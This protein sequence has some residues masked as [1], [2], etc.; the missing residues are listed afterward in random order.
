MCLHTTIAFA[1]PPDMTPT[2]VTAGRSHFALWPVD[3]A[4]L[5]QRLLPSETYFATS[6][7][8]C[9]C[10]TMI[11][12]ANH[13]AA[14]GLVPSEA[15]AREAAKLRAKGWGAHKI[16]R[17]LASKAEAQD[18][19]HRL[20]ATDIAAARESDEIREWLSLLHELTT[21]GRSVALMLHNGDV[22]D[23]TAFAE[24]TV[25]VPVVTADWLVSGVREDVL[26]RITAADRRIRR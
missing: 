6:A 3:N 10:D 5:Q 25:A 19:V 2:Q 13:S 18:K 21:K 4:A 23:E 8:W 17:W 7:S 26:Y 22:T 9:Q 14:R 12:R 15:I 20:L 11:G 16:E 24:E 1:L